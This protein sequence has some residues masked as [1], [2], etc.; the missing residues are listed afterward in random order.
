MLWIVSY[1]Y[2]FVSINSVE[3]DF[4]KKCSCTHKQLPA[5]FQPLQLDGEKKYINTQ[6]CKKKYTELYFYLSR[7]IGHRFWHTLRVDN[8]SRAS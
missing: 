5:P 4:G 8:S 6:K 2:Y 1:M 3:K 7:T